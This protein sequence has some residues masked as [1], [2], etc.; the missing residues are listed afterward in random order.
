MEV[1]V[2][3]HVNLEH[4]FFFL[5]LGQYYT[6]SLVSREAMHQ[7]SN[8]IIKLCPKELLQDSSFGECFCSFHFYTE[9]SVAICR[10]CYICVWD[11]ELC[12]YIIV[13]TLE[14]LDLDLYRLF[15]HLL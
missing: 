2:L 8:D 7:S 5:L 9:F 13:T 15:L 10:G 11:Q 3:D 1:M 14:I 12:S 6:T 4:I